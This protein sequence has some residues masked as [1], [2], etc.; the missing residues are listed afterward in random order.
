MSRRMQ[1]RQTRTKP[2]AQQH[3]CSAGDHGFTLIEV[4]VVITLMGICVVAVLAGMRA[5]ISAT[6]IDRNHAVAF[7]WLQ[8]ASDEI[9]QVG[10]VSCAPDPSNPSQPFGRD[11]AIAQYDKAAQT[12]AVPPVW[13]G[14]TATISVTNVEYLGRVTVDS[15]F[16]WAPSFCFEGAGTEYQSSP[17]YTQRVTIQ[18]TG[19][20]G[21]MVQT[22]EM[23]K[24][25]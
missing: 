17:L 19:P 3:G 5:T 13:N 16:E 10:R 23:V 2:G 24:S 20:D 15:D 18:A 9:Y 12:A 22:L 1:I 8:A 11:A 7:E 6:V 4:L 25:E 14:T 21:A